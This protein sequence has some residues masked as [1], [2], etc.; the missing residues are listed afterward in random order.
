[1]KERISISTLKKFLA[2]LEEKHAALQHLR[3]GAANV[4]LQA[5]LPRIGQLHAPIQAARKRLA[6][7]YNLFEILKIRHYEATVHTPFL[8]NLLSPWGRHEQGRLFY[9]A[10]I[11]QVVDQEDP[12]LKPLLAGDV[13]EAQGEKYAGSFG[14]I[15]IWLKVR[16]QNKDYCIIIENKIYARDQER[17]LE[18]YFRYARGERFAPDQIRL[19]YLSLWKDG[20][21]NEH[22]I[23]PSLAN[24]LESR[25]ILHYINYRQ[26]ILPMLRAVVSNLQAQRLIVN[27]EQYI[28]MVE[29]L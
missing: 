15:D 12:L 13:I 1:M 27:I 14:D 16:F 19:Y 8:V 5:F 26:D 18:R 7:D 3:F 25:R 2:S 21:P 9:E 20:R 24:L 10:F 4:S 22:S 29:F 11:N 28:E 6:P 17:Q 23:R